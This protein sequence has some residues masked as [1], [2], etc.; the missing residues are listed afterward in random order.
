[1][2]T[3]ALQ[4]NLATYEQAKSFIDKGEDCCIVNPCGSGKSSVISELINNYANKNIIVITKQGNAENYYRKTCPVFDKNH[5]RVYTYNAL[6]NLYK[7]DMLE[8]L[9]DTDI[10]IFD[11]AH[12]IGARKWSKAVAALK[13]IS[14]CISVGVTATPQRYEDQGSDRTITKEFDDNIAGNYSTKYLQKTG[15]FIEP[16]YYVSLASLENEINNKINQINDSDLDDKIKTKYIEKLQAVHDEWLKNDCPQKL[17]P[18]ILPKYM[19]K[20]SGN[21]IVV[22]C[23]NTETIPVDVE[24]IIPILCKTFP[25]KKIKAYC[26]SYK[27]GEKEFQQFLNDNSNYINV[28][29]SVNKICETIHISDLNILFFLRS[30]TSYRIITQQIGRINDINNP[31]KGLIIDMVDN[32]SNYK[33]N[34][35]SKEPHGEHDCKNNTSH[36]ISININYIKHC[37]NIFDEIDNA[38]RKSKVYS[39]HDIK[40][41]INQLCYVFRKYASKVKQHMADGYEFEDAMDFVDTDKKY[42]TYE[43]RKCICNPISEDAK[44]IIQ[45]YYPAIQEIMDSK[46]CYDE[47]IAANLAADLCEIAQIY[48]DTK[49]TTYPSAYIRTTLLNRLLYYLRLSNDHNT[50]EN[51]CDT[52]SDIAD[53]SSIESITDYKEMQKLLTNARNTL[54]NREQQVINIRFGFGC[55][56]HTL[57][58]TAKFMNVTS[59][60]IRQ[61]EAKALRKLRHP[62]RSR[63]LK[64][65]LEDTYK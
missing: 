28:L 8:S 40:G 44:V 49:S 29:F 10:T 45:Q 61:L 65:F 5:I 50:Y 42:T 3:I 2:H 17:I 51:L 63:D 27:S 31:N 18:N 13:T 64:P 16:D 33:T 52:I 7:N 46:N 6:Y 57:E 41:S 43:S 1:M 25:G 22:F 38:T 30:A 24:Y 20:P 59:E 26:Y 56:M 55:R 32:L 39:Y 48:V 12:Y 53:S 62:N 9:S 36:N 4:H 23:K 15:V 11:E 34:S 14:S 35:K 47:D 19:Y 54:T 37:L 58:E 60:R 21:K